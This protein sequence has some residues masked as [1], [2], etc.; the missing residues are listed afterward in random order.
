MTWKCAVVDV[1]FGGGKAGI[2]ID[3]K[4]Y[5][6]NELE[7]I[8][9]K[10]ATEL[11]KKGFLGPAIDVPAPDMATGEREMKSFENVSLFCKMIV[12]TKNYLKLCRAWMADQYAKTIGHG[13]MNAP[14]CVTGKPISQGGI[15]G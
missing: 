12:L 15:H 10:F 6:A 11:A 5:S 1:P 8:T 4:K 13:D 14:G 3:A 7:R 2:K 9:R